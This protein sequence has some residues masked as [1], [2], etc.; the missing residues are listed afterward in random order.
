MPIYDV[1]LYATIHLKVK[2]VDANSQSEAV[3]LAQKLDY[4]EVL[5]QDICQFKCD[6][7]QHLEYTDFADEITDVL[8]DEMGDEDYTNSHWYDADGNFVQ[9][10]IS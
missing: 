6:S 7:N 8:V 2:N 9:G 3:R 5:T 10:E 4:M 1:H